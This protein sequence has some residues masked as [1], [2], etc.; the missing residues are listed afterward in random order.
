MSDHPVSIRSKSEP[1]NRRRRGKM[2]LLA[3][4]L[5][6]EEEKCLFRDIHFGS[7][8][9]KNSSA[10]IS[11][12]ISATK[13]ALS[14]G[15]RRNLIERETRVLSLWEFII[16]W[17]TQCLDISSLKLFRLPL[18]PCDNQPSADL[19]KTSSQKGSRPRGFF[20]LPYFVK[21]LQICDN[22]TKNT[23]ACVCVCVG[24]ERTKS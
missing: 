12:F 4:S 18:L 13:S 15:K 17:W 21:T 7:S 1:A 16:I 3:R 24:G 9:G 20:L 23:Y 14:V 6:E 22:T 2:T 5:P 10:P 11:I 8:P 19:E